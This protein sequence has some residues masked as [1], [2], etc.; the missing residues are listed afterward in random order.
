MKR[1]A[2]KLQ[3]KSAFHF[4]REG[5][6]QHSSAETFPSDSLF[7]AIVATL[8]QTNPQAVNGFI[9]AFPPYSNAPKL[10]LSSVFPLV[11]DLP[12]FPKPRVAIE[13][14][15]GKNDGSN[16]PD[17]DESG[18]KFKQ[19]R[20]V[21][22]EILKN[23]L[24]HAPMN[25][26]LDP[27]QAGYFLQGDE[28]WLSRNE[29]K[30]LPPLESDKVWDVD[31]APRVTIDRITNESNVYQTG[32]TLFSEGCGLWFMAEVSE[33]FEVTLQ[34]IMSQLGDSGIGGER[35]SGYGGFECSEIAVPQLPYSGGKYVMLLSRY[36]PTAKE[37]QENLLT[38]EQCAYEIV[39][40]GGWSG[41]Y[42]RPR[43]R[44]LEVGSIVGGSNLSGQLVDV[45]PSAH[46][47]HKIYRSGIAL[48]I[49]AGGE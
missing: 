48:T 31:L 23:I 6:E 32:R 17:F 30:S 15:S 8:A 7:S 10:R 24:N 5:L 12:L 4:G 40:V 33:D 47:R 14:A 1:L 29:S 36:N 22:G 42:K 27:K 37:L 21:S 25:D 34:S 44:M 18:K 41:P 3:P 19:I 43:V 39:D 13:K 16:S 38:G 49:S 26:L 35:S 9:G 46:N 11:G 28:I 20:Y 2:F 45:T